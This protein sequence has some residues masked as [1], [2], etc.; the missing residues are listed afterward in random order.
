MQNIRKFPLDGL[1]Q[2]MT[3]KPLRLLTSIPL[4]DIFLS[5]KAPSPS[6]EH[7]LTQAL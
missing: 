3:I 6:Q 2:I 7:Q 4:Q 1:T 5:Q